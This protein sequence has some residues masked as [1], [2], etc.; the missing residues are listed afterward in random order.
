[1]HVGMMFPC[2]YCSYKNG[3]SSEL[4][5]LK[6]EGLINKQK[7]QFSKGR[8]EREKLWKL[9]KASCGQS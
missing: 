2:N 8:K 6:S 5:A 7:R 1:M 9:D 4:E 3:S